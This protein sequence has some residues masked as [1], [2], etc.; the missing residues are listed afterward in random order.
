M[1]QRYDQRGDLDRIAP[2]QFQESA[3]GQRVFFIDSASE[4]RMGSNNIFIAS[5]ENNKNTVTTARS[6]RVEVTNDVQM[7]ILQNGQRLENTIGKPDL[8]V[9]DFEEYGISTGQRKDLAAD[10]IEIRAMSTLGLFNS[11]NNSHR[12]E[13]SW[14]FGLVFSAVNFVVLA[15]ALAAVNPRAGRSSNVIFVLLIF[16]LYSN[17]IG[18][19]Q[20]W[21][22]SG[23]I[24]LGS[25]L[26]LMHGSVFTGSLLWLAKRN[27]N[28]SIT[29]LLPRR[30]PPAQALAVKSSVK[31]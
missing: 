28:W 31:P 7:L 21:V 14:R 29:D 6:G 26:L 27:E 5:V 22:S 11:N 23:R 9:S 24:G 25:L 16:I 13:L 18:L 10:A 20:T 1:K 19:G 12:A 30:P 8:R 17:L 2:G 3:N 4:G 15:L